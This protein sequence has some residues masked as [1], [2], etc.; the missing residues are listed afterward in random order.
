MTRFPPGSSPIPM[1]LAGATALLAGGCVSSSTWSSWHATH[2]RIEAIE[3]EERDVVDGRSGAPASDGSRTFDSCDEVVR[4]V[5]AA[6]PGL[7]APR[8]RARAALASAR[9]EG[10]LPAPSVSLAAWDFPIGDPQLADREGMYMLAVAQELPPP[11]SLDASAAAAVE[12]A[13][14]ALGELDEMRRM[15]SA[16][17]AH[18]CADWAGAAALVTALRTWIETLRTMRD[19]VIARYSA[20]GGVLADV[21]RVDREIATAERMIAR[22]LGDGDRAKEGLRARLGVSAAAEL[23]A[24]PA[25]PADVPSIDE[26]AALAFALDHRGILAAASAGIAAAE[27]RAEAARARADIPTFMFGAM[28]MQTP[29]MRAGLGLEFGMTLPWL[30]SG[31]RDEAEAARAEANAME[32]E[33]A[34]IERSISV[35]VRTALAALATVRRALAALRELEAPAAALA[36]DATAATYGAGDGT[37]LEW[38]DAARAIRELEIQEVELLMEVAHALA[39]LASALGALPADLASDPLTATASE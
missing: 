8:E 12:E 31:E 26:G 25:L 28:Y 22:A 7:A 13:R 23:G 1:A 10:A 3:A 36:L 17:A 29:Q 16:D 33:A 39:D 35:E 32:A 9:A 24:P 27:A 6:S 38:L 20:A 4:E 15:I 14:A 34:G 37:L 2:E 5:I 18:A 21:A 30:W 11:G 19:A